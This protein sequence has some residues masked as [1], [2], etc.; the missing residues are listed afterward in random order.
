MGLGTRSPSLSRLARERAQTPKKGAGCFARSGR[1]RT[2]TSAA[3]VFGIQ[4]L[5]G[6]GR[7]TIQEKLRAAEALE[8]LPL[9][10]RELESG[11]LSRCAAR[12][13]TRVAAADTEG[14]W[15]VAA[16]GKTI[17]QL[18]NR[19]PGDGP[20]APPSHWPRPRVLR[21]EVAPETF[22]LFREALQ[23]LRRSA[24]ERWDDDTRHVLVRPADEGRSSY[25]VLLTVCAAC[26]SGEQLAGGEVVPVGDA[27]VAMAECDAQPLGQLA[28]TPD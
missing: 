3:A 9:I 12:E 5:F 10:G 23:Q 15:L 2:F 19:S 16:H 22:G 21:F 20:S 7:R 18:G 25:Q 1:P 27:V 4:R 8:V 11:A 26:S 17:R 6:Y 28:K 24:R 14:A 13:L